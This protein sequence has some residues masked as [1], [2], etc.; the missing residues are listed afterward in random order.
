MDGGVRVLP[1]GDRA[2]LVEVADGAAVAAVRTALERSPLPGQL[3]DDATIV[4]MEWR[5]GREDKLRP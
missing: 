1:C 2:L 3:Q 4:M 5:T